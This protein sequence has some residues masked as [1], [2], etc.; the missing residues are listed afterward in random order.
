MQYARDAYDTHDVLCNRVSVLGGG[1]VSSQ[2][3]IQPTRL[4]HQGSQWSHA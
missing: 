1:G 4:L 2:L 3:G